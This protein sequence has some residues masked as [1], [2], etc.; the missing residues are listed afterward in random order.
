MLVGVLGYIT[1]LGVFLGDLNTA[2]G[3]LVVVILYVV[4]E[5]RSGT[6]S[7]TDEYAP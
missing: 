6:F 7:G 3:V 1:W 4:F 2:A 5:L